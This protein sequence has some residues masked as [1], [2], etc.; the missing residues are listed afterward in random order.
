MKKTILKTMAA[1]PAVILMSVIF[2]FSAAE[3]P[4]STK[5]SLTVSFKL[6]RAAESIGFLHLNPVQEY[7]SAVAIEGPIRKLAHITEYTI[8]AAAVYIMFI[9]WTNRRILLYFVTVLFSL[10]YAA[11]DEVHQLFV[12]GRSGS[13][14]DV[15]VDAIGVTIGAMI[16]LAIDNI[17]WPDR[18]EKDEFD[19]FWKET[20]NAD[21]KK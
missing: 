17:F 10:M 19:W 4:E 5:S 13:F 8:L 7:L 3:A 2:I 12:K 18:S 14:S 15:C 21:R 11:S 20:T 9:L 16:M 6:I 1:L